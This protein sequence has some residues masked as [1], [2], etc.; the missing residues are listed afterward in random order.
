LDATFYPAVSEDLSALSRTAGPVAIGRHRFL[1]KQYLVK[2]RPPQHVGQRADRWLKRLWVHAGQGMLDSF[3]EKA[4]TIVIFD[5]G[6]FRSS[7]ND[8]GKP[9]KT[10]RLS[11]AGEKLCWLSQMIK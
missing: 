2:S 8:G 3:A 4:P 9:Q 10:G 1:Q 7:A 11:G 5:D 6:R